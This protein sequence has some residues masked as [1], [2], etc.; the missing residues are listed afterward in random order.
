ME[1]I[2]NFNTLITLQVECF[3]ETFLLLSM[4][5]TPKPSVLRTLNLCLTVG[6]SLLLL[7][8]EVDRWTVDD[9]P[10]AMRMSYRL[11]TTNR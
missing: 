7:L 5:C 8:S 3:L 11:T 10:S 4:L 6:D 1:R 9:G 2:L